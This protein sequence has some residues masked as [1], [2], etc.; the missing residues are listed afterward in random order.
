MKLSIFSKNQHKHSVWS[1]GTTTQLIISPSDADYSKR[2]FDFRISTAVVESQESDFTP[3]PG[4]DRKLMLLNGTIIINHK[5]Q[6]R[7]QLLPFEVESFKGEW[8]TSSIGVCTDFNV[9]TTGNTKSELWS[10][11][12]DH[13]TIL[14]TDKPYDT[15]CV[16]I[17]SGNPSIEIDNNRLSLNEKSFLIIEDSSQLLFPLFTD[18]ECTIIISTICK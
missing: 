1:G 10:L 13:T 5:K 9:M 7:K 17:H 15:L 14:K 16:Y 12:F 8:E 3:L 18:E 6:Y 2:N 4:V 11:I